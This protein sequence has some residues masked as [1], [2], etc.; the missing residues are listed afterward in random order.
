[1]ETENP[2]SVGTL[3]FCHSSVHLTSVCCSLLSGKCQRTAFPV[4]FP[5]SASGSSLLVQF[6]RKQLT[7]CFLEAFDISFSSDAK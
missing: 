3:F 5:S 1:M 4:S 7:C 6:V 2:S